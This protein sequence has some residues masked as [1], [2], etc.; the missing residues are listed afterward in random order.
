M[1]A[2]KKKMQMTNVQKTREAKKL[3]RRDKEVQKRVDKKRI[4]KIKEGQVAED[5]GQ[6]KIARM[7][8]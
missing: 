3:T 7:G 5:N 6:Q 8:R 2:E 4:E 1:R